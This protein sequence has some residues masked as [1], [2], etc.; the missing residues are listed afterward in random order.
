MLP[1]RHI[2][3]TVCHTQH[4]LLVQRRDLE[5]RALDNTHDCDH[6]HTSMWIAIRCSRRCI[7][8]TVASL[9]VTLCSMRETPAMYR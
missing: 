5:R 7:L 6:S 8:T 4:D 1:E 9:Y 3:A 2:Y